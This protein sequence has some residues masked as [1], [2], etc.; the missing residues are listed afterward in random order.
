MY[1]DGNNQI[2][3][4]SYL[5]RRGN[6]IVGIRRPQHK[7]INPSYI[8]IPEPV[9]DIDK[10]QDK[11][12]AEREAEVV[13]MCEAAELGLQPCHRL[14]G[15]NAT[16]VKFDWLSGLLIQKIVPSICGFIDG[17]LLLGRPYVTHSP[18]IL[19]SI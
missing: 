7:S 19:Q 6:S 18:F 9:A 2:A 4:M 1:D 11:D 16:N 8:A 3:T 15:K 17:R 13:A 10:H 5:V 14:Y 12:E